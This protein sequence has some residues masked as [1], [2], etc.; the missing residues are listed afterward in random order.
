MYK[1]IWLEDNSDC[2]ICGGNYACGYKIEKDGKVLVDKTPY[3]HCFS[4]SSDYNPSEAYTDI[5]KDAGI[6]VVEEDSYE[7][8][9]EDINL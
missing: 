3:A 6:E 5:L 9:I 8:Y 4:G 2:E 1:I 7:Q